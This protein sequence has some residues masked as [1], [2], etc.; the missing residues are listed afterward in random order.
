MNIN[1]L[2]L[3]L[4]P[5]PPAARPRTGTESNSEIKAS[6]LLARAPATLSGY[7]YFPQN[8]LSFMSL[9]YSSK[10]SRRTLLSRTPRQR[11]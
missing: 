2:D 7:D 9:E 6:S 1:S 8:S 3:L 11:S 5:A 4:A 10:A